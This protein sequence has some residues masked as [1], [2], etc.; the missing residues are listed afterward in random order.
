[1]KQK[2]TLSKNSI[3]GKEKTKVVDEEKTELLEHS[4]GLLRSLKN[5][6]SKSRR[7]INGCKSSKKSWRP[8]KYYLTKTTMGTQKMPVSWCTVSWDPSI[9]PLQALLT[10]D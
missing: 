10:N 7:L 6:L 5:L 1:M 9:C 2:K 4:K 8:R 3:V